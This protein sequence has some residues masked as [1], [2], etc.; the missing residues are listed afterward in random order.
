MWALVSVGGMDVDQV[1][2]GVWDTYG[3]RSLSIVGW[4]WE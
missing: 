3:S 1:S 2:V 4:M